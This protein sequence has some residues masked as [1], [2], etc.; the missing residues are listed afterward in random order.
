MVAI[1]AGPGLGLERTSGWVLGGIG[2]LGQATLGRGDENVYVNAANGNLVIQ[3][4][5]E[6]LNDFG[7]SADEIRQLLASGAAMQG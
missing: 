4:T 1:V 2:Q 6:V 7:F 5:D 3:Q